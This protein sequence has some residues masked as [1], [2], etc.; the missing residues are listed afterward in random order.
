M[1]FYIAHAKIDI[2]T[3]AIMNNRKIAKNAFFLYIRMF[4]TMGISLFT[5]RIVLRTLGETDFGIYNIVGGIIILFSFLNA[6]LTT[7]TQRYLS[8]ALGKEDK[9][10]FNMFFSI[11]VTCFIATSIALLVLSETLGVWF[12]NTYLN[13]PSE[14]MFAANIVFQ[15][16]ILTFIAQILRIPYHA[17]VIAHEKM[18]FFALM[19]IIEAILKLFIVYALLIIAYD[20]LITYSFLMSLVVFIVLFIYYL[21]CNKKFAYIRYSFCQDWSKIRDFLSF[22]TWSL[23][24]GIANIGSQQALNFMLNI[25]FGVT[26]NAAI[27]IANQVTGAIYTFVTNFQTAFN[28][29]IIKSYATKDFPACQKLV[30]MASKISYFLL[31]IIGFPIIVNIDYILYLWL[32]DVPSYTNQFI[33]IIFI[34]QLIDAISMPFLT[35][36]QAKG[37][38]RNYQIIISLLILIN[39]PLAYIV[40]RVGGNPYLIWST[41]IV[42]NIFCFIYRCYYVKKYISIDIWGFVKGVIG[43]ISLITAICTPPVILIKNNIEDELLSLMYSLVSSVLISL[44]SIYIWGLNSAERTLVKKFVSLKHK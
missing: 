34:Y 9:D 12:L 21:F 26:V 32:G 1:A 24:G 14:R 7:A 36:I 11:S 13:I 8:Y 35:C 29:Q 38:I 17:T 41:K 19:S 33:S 6:A 4:I 10:T 5:S 43:R 16:S 22:S 27:G 3:K 37:G 30:F 42:V 28:P 40:L 15:F 25:F 20:K 31:F 18:D 23:F 2:G 44:I 39:I